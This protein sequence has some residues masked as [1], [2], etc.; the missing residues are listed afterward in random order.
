MSVPSS[1]VLEF[2]RLG[3]VRAARAYGLLVGSEQRAGEPEPVS[4]VCSGDAVVGIVFELQGEVGGLVALLLPERACVQLLE[5]LCPGVDP[6]SVRAG[7]GHG[8]AGPVSGC[9][10]S[11]RDCPASS[12][13]ASGSGTDEHAASVGC[14]G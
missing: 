7:H 1:R 4:G 12:G 14:P 8:S 5:S 3:A 2:A 9:P 13:S 10:A 11:D 6:G